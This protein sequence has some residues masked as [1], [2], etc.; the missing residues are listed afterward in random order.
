MDYVL[1]NIFG[2]LWMVVFMV[3]KLFWMHLI[4]STDEEEEEDT[5]KDTGEVDDDD[6]DDD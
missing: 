2:E 1:R 3:S 4:S 6:D 5:D